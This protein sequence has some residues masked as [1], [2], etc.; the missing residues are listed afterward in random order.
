MSRVVLAD[1]AFFDAVQPFVGEAVKA[2]DAA[3]AVRFSL[4]APSVLAIGPFLAP[5]AALEVASRL[6]ARDVKVVMVVRELSPS[7]MRSAMRAGVRDVVSAS[8]PPI[9]IAKALVEVGADAHGECA[10]MRQQRGR[11]V[12]V[13][14][15]KGGVGK[16]TLATN[17][18]AALAARHGVDTVL[19]DLDMQF[20]DVAIMLQM[21]PK[22]TLYDAAQAGDRL[23]ADMLEGFLAVHE[24]GLRALL[25]AVSPEQA[26][27]IGAPKIGRILDLLKGMADLVM[28]DTPAT[29]DDVVLTAVGRSD[30]VLAVAT[31]DVPSVKNTK[32]SLQ[33]LRQLGHGERPVRVVLNRANSKVWLPFSEVEKAIGM[34]VGVRIPSDRTVPRCVN[35]GVPVVLDDPRSCAGRALLSLADTLVPERVVEGVA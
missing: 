34:P 28:V 25:A 22:T 23:D 19:V 27:A 18:C 7:L 20:G 21:V 2:K 11:I 15:G 12:T 9:E 24:C 30:E 8:E 6:T 31:L 17:V 4:A 5:D 14:G 35:K 32:V 3:E 10:R 1:P 16:T 33:K 26:D 29:L 13:F